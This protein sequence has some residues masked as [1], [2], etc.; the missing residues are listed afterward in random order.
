V[1]EVLVPPPGQPYTGVWWELAAGLPRWTAG[2][3]RVLLADY[4]KTLRY[5]CVCVIDVEAA[6]ASTPPPLP[7]QRAQP[8]P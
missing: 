2:G 4:D 1:A 8:V 6:P 5:L 7:A 3:R